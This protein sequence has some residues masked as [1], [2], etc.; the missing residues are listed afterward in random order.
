MP[1]VITATL[2][3]TGKVYVVPEGDWFATIHQIGV[4]AVIFDCDGTLVNSSI[5]H[6]RSMKSAAA[7]QGHDMTWDWY[8]ARTGL[9]RI[10]L[11]VEFGG[12]VGGSF[13]RQRA[14]TD[15][16]A[17]FSQH[18]DTVT[19]IPEM[20]TLFDQL[21]IAGYPL[22]VGTNA[23]REIAVQSLQR[24]GVLSRLSAVVSISD[25]VAP[26]PSPEIFQLAAKKLGTSS[27]MTLVIEDSSQGL[28]AAM[29]AGM[30]ALKITAPK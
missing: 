19:P 27:A 14:V 22:A 28:S 23:E 24:A 6:F 17:V 11:F 29:A 20:I 30:P 13:D 4:S 1:S 2:H 18:A 21:Y 7:L 16:I 3:H 5:A 25:K 15:S 26:K 12:I 8:S 10:S 9:D